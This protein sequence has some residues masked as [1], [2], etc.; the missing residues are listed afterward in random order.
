V[1]GGW[2]E[3]NKYDFH[4]LGPDRREGDALSLSSPL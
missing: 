1:R 2:I 3:L 4:A